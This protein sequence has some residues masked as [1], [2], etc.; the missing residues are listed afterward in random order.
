VTRDM[1]AHVKPDPD[2]FLAGAAA[3]RTVCRSAATRRTERPGS[4]IYLGTCVAGG[5]RILLGTSRGNHRMRSCR[6][7]AVRS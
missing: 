7:C 1:V 3:W 4:A 5:R 6:S 2:L